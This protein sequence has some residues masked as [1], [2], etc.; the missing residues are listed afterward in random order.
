VTKLVAAAVLAAVASVPLAGQA[1][2]VPLR[3]SMTLQGSI[4]DHV[5]YTQTR[6]DEDCFIRRSG[7]GRSEL[8]VRSVRRTIVRLLDAEGRTR[9]RPAFVRAVRVSGRINAGVYGETRLCRGAPPERVQGSCEGVRF[10]PVTV[11]AS[12]HRPSRNA[13]RFGSAPVAARAGVR[14]CGID[15]RFEGGWL[16]LVPGRVS[17]RAFRAGARVVRARGATP[18]TAFLQTP[19]TETEQRTTVDWTLTFRRLR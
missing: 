14:A 19:I 17:E 8:V 7:S 10:G 4:A 5:E 11:R 3:Y 13:I 1:A 9:Y 15:L 16:H 2:T 12:F 18:T 6:R